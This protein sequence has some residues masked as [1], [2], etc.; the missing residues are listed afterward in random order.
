MRLRNWIVAPL[1]ALI[2]FNVSARAAEPTPTV[3]VRVKSIDGLMADA[4][5]LA[6]L[7]GQGE[8][9]KQIDGVIPAF[10][11]PKGLAETGLDTSRPW[12]LYAILKPEIPNS[13]VVLTLGIV[14]GCPLRQQ[15]G[16]KER[17]GIQ[18]EQSVVSRDG[19]I[20]IGHRA[21][22]PAHLLMN[23][24]A[25]PIGLGE[26]RIDLDRL[27]QIGHRA[28]QIVPGDE[29]ASPRGKRHDVLR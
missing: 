14:G 18:F 2:A 21:V 25:Q 4:R 28:R 16:P 23:Q 20:E 9:F 27:I 29:G 12:G 13:P 24:A 1:L 8:A 6:G 7:A 15:V 10:L 5:Y 22:M 11:G 26:V 3:L 19:A 17:G